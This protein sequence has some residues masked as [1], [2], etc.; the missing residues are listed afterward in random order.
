MAPLVPRL[1]S[2]TYGTRTV[3][4]ST[5]IDI[6]GPV[7][8]VR[9]ADSCQVS[10]H[11]IATASTSA[12]AAALWIALEADLATPHKAITITMDSETV[13][14]LSPTTGANTGFNARSSIVKDG[15]PTLDSRLSRRYSWQV[16]FDTPASL[17]A[18][19]GRRVS[20][21]TLA[22]DAGGIGSVNVN[23]EYRAL[24]GNDAYDQYVAAIDAFVTLIF[25]R[26]GVTQSRY[27]LLNETASSDDRDKIA[28]V[29]QAW[30]EITHPDSPGAYN[31]SVIRQARLSVTKSQEQ[32][33]Y[34]PG[35]PTVARVQTISVNYSTRVPPGAAEGTSDLVATYKG[36]SRPEILDTI[37]RLIGTAYIKVEQVTYD[38]TTRSITAGM[39]LVSYPSDVDQYTRRDTDTIDE[40]RV[41][42]PVWSK[43]NTERDSAYVYD[44]P[45]IVM[46]STEEMWSHDPSYDPTP[47]AAPSDGTWVPLSRSR[48]ITL[49]VEAAGVTRQQ[50]RIS[51]SW[52][53]VTIYTPPAITSTSVVFSEG[54]GTAGEGDY[55]P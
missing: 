41:I 24:G 29:S 46:H 1:L 52:R 17:Y 26:F 28:N 19:S 50:T 5:D 8:I 2:I 38:P 49:M 18:S 53:R 14:S 27:E 10:C 22:R 39:T 20:N 6:D 30:K 40:G 16:H 3:G 12:A 45:R 34:S 7:R 21:S 55:F 51:Q 4:G 31:S 25:T 13:L 33:G 35:G 11:L 42:V 47:A 15:T 37:R 23:A 44:G 36:V 32:G 9:D 54:A 48:P 43:D